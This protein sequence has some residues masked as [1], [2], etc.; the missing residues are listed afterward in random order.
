MRP[1]FL[2]PL[3]FGACLAPLAAHAAELTI[4]PSAIFDAVL[5]G[6][7]ADGEGS[8]MIQESLGIYN[9]HGGHEHEGEGEEA[10]GGHSHGGTL[11]RGFNFRSAEL[12]LNAQL[13]GWFDGRFLFVTD[14]KEGEVEE[15]W[16]RTQFLPGG[17]QLKGGKMFSDV[18][19]LNNQHPHTWD[20]VD[21]AL[22]YQM[23]LG[24]NLGGGGVQLSWLAP[25]PFYL[26]LGAEALSGDNPGI[27]AHIGPTT[28]EDGDPIAFDRKGNWPNVWTAFAKFGGEVARNH[29]VQGGLSWIHSKHH[30]ELHHAHPGI[31]EAD[32]GLQGEASMWGVDMVYKFDAAGAEGLGDIKL[33]AEYW[34][35]NKDLSL[36]FHELKPRLVG[37]P[38]DLTVDGAYI[39]ALY[40]IA[41]R[42]QVGVRYDIAGMTHKASR[43]GSTVGPTNTSHFDDMDRISAV[44]TW[45]ISH[46]QQ[47]R[48]QI[49]HVSAPVAEDSNGDGKDEAVRKSFNQ[50]FLQYQIGLGAHGAHG[51]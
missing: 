31:N 27:A 42:W 23:L 1:S 7:D 3:L 32:H 35:Q 19:Y 39:Q 12:A 25:T 47:L 41:P 33:Q 34:R 16:L 45:N 28:S 43:A 10:G 46:N 22:P 9:V 2:S 24:G 37:Q 5:Y 11:D 40:G 30:Q 13:P 18:G 14:G 26:R 44:A 20:F 17:L 29:E 38:R 36:T 48:F 8:H 4:Q 15:A 6:D 50:V 49:S 21:Q 51:F